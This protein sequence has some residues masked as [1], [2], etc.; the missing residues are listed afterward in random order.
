MIRHKSICV[1]IPFYICAIVCVRAP[2]HTYIRV[3]MWGRLSIHVYIDGAMGNLSPL[4]IF[5]N[6]YSLLSFFLTT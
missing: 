3:Y 2:L 1:R 4:D 6:V 5:N